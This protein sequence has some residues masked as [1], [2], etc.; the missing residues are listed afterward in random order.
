VQQRLLALYPLYQFL[1]PIKS[2]RIG[3]SGRHALVM[4]DLAVEFDA[5]VAHCSFHFTASFFGKRSQGGSSFNEAESGQGRVSDRHR[6]GVAD[7]VHLRAQR[8]ES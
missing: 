3:G 7:L 1:N 5:L 2:I 4:L 6:Q 8:H